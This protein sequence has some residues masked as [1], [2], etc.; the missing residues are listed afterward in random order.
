MTRPIPYVKIGLDFNFGALQFEALKL[1]SKVKLAIFFIPT[2]ISTLNFM[3]IT[4]NVELLHYCFLKLIFKSLVEPI[5]K[6]WFGHKIQKI[7]DMS[8]KF[9]KVTLGVHM[10]EID[11]L[12]QNLRGSLQKFPRIVWFSDKM[13]L[14]LPLTIRYHY[15]QYSSVLL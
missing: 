10:S 15:A 5:F 4:E 3:I 12:R 7:S 8:K 11:Q 6:N 1:P 2:Q 9:C 13:S 14:K